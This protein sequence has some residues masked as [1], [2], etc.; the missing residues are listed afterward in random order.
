MN[1]ESTNT[2]IGY[3]CT[4]L[5]V[6]KGRGSK[7]ALR[8]ISPSREVRDFT[9]AD[10]R[11][12]SN[13]AANLLLARGVKPGDSL[14]FLL[15]RVPELFTFFL[16]ALKLGANACVLFTSIGEETL[17]DRIVETDTH[18]V[19]TN[20]Q[21]LY[22]L[23][24]LFAGSDYAL[25]LLIIDSRENAPQQAGIQDE[26]PLASP[27]FTVQPTPKDQPSHFHFTS[28]S[29]G[30]PKGVQHVHGGAEAHLA[31]FMEVMQPVDDDIYWCTAD[32]GWVTGTTY[33]IIAPWY[34]GLTQIQFA[35]NFNAA[36]WMQILQDQ[37]VTLLYSAPTVFRMLMQNPDEFF[38]PYD[39]SRLKRIYAVGEPLNPVIIKWSRSVLGKEIYDTWF[40]TE[41]GSILVANRP[42]IEV[43]PGSMGKPLSY[44]DAKILDTKGIP[45]SLKDEGLLC[46]RKPWPSMFCTYI[47]HPDVY[48]RK[49]YGEYYS[50]GDIAYQ[51]ED[52]YVWFV[53][54][55][56]DIINTA[57]HLVS[58][59]EVESALLELPEVI[60]V[61]VVAAPDDVLFEK[62]LA[63]VVLRPDMSLTHALDLKIKLHVSKA[64]S[65]IASPRE[66]I[67]VPKIPKTKSGKIMRR[68]LKNQYL[69]L[70]LGDTSTLEE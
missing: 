42:G 69:H 6:E 30:K 18:V 21:L 37:K 46:I 51:D 43:R 31:S 41:T 22:K 67:V 55:N 34:R 26:I 63:F 25:E 68:L 19:V 52:G 70:E 47:K 10:L 56:D 48:A 39:L 3:L 8:W 59:F 66:I 15:P 61:G 45:V 23:A 11:D 53:G 24:N 65:S 9:F 5:Q 20:T 14:M 32:P 1:T 64:V 17:R 36:A 35:G 16:G 13:R 27:H 54:R 44:I 7:V 50:S 60:D 28:G 57:G 12:A 33:G 38:A 58:P 29:T 49:F 4:D 2:N 62:V 40:Q